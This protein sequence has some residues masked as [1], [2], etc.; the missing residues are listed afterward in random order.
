MIYL[1]I[2]LGIIYWV[3]SGFVLCIITT[4]AL[5]PNLD[6]NDVD[7]GL[8]IA[9]LFEFMIAPLCLP[10]FLLG[11]L[12]SYCCKKIGMFKIVKFNYKLARKLRDRKKAKENE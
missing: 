1:Y 12:L 7:G 4:N 2:I 5:A 10:F 3:I 9:W 11:M 8:F 6:E